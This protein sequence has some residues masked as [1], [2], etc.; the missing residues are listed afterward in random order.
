[1]F[2]CVYARTLTERLN[3]VRLIGQRR[4][5]ERI[6]YG[7]V[8]VQPPARLLLC[9]VLAPYAVAR[10]L[11]VDDVTYTHGRKPRVRHT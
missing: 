9:A 8:R 10:H 3:V 2:V 7:K 5:L 11:H 4:H 1:M 6:C